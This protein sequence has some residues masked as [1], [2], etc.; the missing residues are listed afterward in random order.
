MPFDLPAVGKVLQ[1]R[2][3]GGRHEGYYGPSCHQRADP[4]KGNR[5]S[6]HDNDSTATQT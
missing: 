1:G 5:P 2:H 3:G 6:S 4:A